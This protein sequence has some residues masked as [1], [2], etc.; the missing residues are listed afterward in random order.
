MLSFAACGLGVLVPLVVGTEV[1]TPG[2]PFVV[3]EGIVVKRKVEKL[4]KGITQ[5]LGR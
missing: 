1:A 4:L 2:V 5:Q 3:A